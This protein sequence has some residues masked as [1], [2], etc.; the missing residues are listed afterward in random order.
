MERIYTLID[1][2]YLQRQQGSHP[3]QLLLTIQLIQTELLKLQ[4]K[5]G[6]LGSSKVAVT[7]PVNL[8]F[9]EEETR[10][11]KLNFPAIDTAIEMEENH[12]QE[13]EKNIKPAPKKPSFEEITYGLQKP[14][15]E[16]K[17]QEEKRPINKVQQVLNPAF[18][19][20][21]ES[22]TLAQHQ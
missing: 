19:A 4:Q 18:D 17:I 21:V 11:H 15:T 3:A 1:K 6:S 20:E 13:P 14:Y 7:L 22:P 16:E 5:N 8:N 9:S 12:I 2:L 10:G